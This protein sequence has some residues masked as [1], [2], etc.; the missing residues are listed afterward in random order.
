MLREVAQVSGIA[1]WTAACTAISVLAADNSSMEAPDFR[2]VFELIRQN[3]PAATEAELNRAATE[4]LVAKLAPRVT[5]VRSNDT[6]EP[7]NLGLT[8]SN[9]FE[10]SV[11]YLRIGM[12]KLGLEQSVKAAWEQFSA[13]NKMS[14][15]VLDLRYANGED[16]PAAAAVAGLFFQT[17]Q[18]LLDWGAGMAESKEGGAI[19]SCPI[20]I[21]V[22]G[23]TSGASEA[24]AAVLRGAG[25]G[26]ILGSRSAGKAGV[27]K[28]FPLANG[29]R[30]RII[31]RAIRLGDGSQIAAT[32][33]A[34][35]I[36]LEVSPSDERA[37][38]EDPFAP[39]QA[40]NQVSPGGLAGARTNQPVRRPRYGEAE[41]VRDR[42]QG[43]PAD[44]SV[45]RQRAETEGPQLQDAVLLRALDLLKG[46][47][48]VR[49][50]HS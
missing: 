21:L 5:L 43:S 28:D 32:G 46:L 37:Y 47:A 15:V 9:L 2:Q 22:N 38:Y 13:S 31:T 20:A 11:L 41:L 30:L 42:R 35:D 40:V 44:G 14:G 7:V 50:T 39:L 3:L 33:V 25:R 6:I 27:S 34:P 4:G 1:I 26:L 19:G 24:L 12:V 29:D 8:R 36:D 48:I 17:K 49:Q 18:P 16:Y 10:S 23:Q 45:A